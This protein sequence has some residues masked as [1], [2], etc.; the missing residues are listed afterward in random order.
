MSSSYGENI[1]LTVFGQSHGGMIGA[2]LD[3]LPPGEP[4]DLAAMQA[5]VN[6]RAPGRSAYATARR[7]PD[8]VRIVSGLY[9]GKTCGAPL[10]L[11]I[12]NMDAR[13]ADYDKLRD[14]PRPAHADYTATARYGGFA[15]PRGG[16][17][18]SGRLTAPL[19]AAGALCA[20]IIARR[21]VTVGGHI[22][23]LGD[24]HDTA[25]DSLRLTPNRLKETADRDFPVFRAEAAAQMRE[26]LDVAKQAGDSLGGLLEVFALGL[27]A[28]L[29]SPMFGGVE[30]R[31][32][33]AAF[34]IPAVRGVE[35]G[36]GFAA[37]HVSGS[38][39]ND[40]FCARQGLVRTKTNHHGGVLGGIT[41]G[42]PLVMRAAVKPTPSIARPQ[43]TLNLAT[44]REETL[45]ISGRHDPCVALRAL[46]CLEA[47][48]AFVLLDLMLDG[49]YYNMTDGGMRKWICKNKA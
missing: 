39:H 7:E 21:G 32:A 30:N 36:S 10:C 45:C 20:Q 15:D 47:V 35:F 41:S 29:G 11:L 26:A 28:G 5:F 37:A 27:P 42:M 43:Q 33:A 4:V 22:A 49:E 3:G 14:T 25:P 44:M 31:L 9:Q 48:V 12:E 40:A 24:C 19:V 1:R 13:S 2:T 18:F 16:G 34:A 46:P 38:Q 23:A 17:H 6:R 8:A